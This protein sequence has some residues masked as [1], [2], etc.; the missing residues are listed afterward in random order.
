MRGYKIKFKSCEVVELNERQ[1]A[2][3]NNNDTIDKGKKQLKK[4]KTQ[5]LTISLQPYNK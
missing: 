4:S 5:A 3:S 2:K 1:S